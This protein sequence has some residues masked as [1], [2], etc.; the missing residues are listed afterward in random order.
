M[1]K[2]IILGLIIGIMLCLGIVILTGNAD[3]IKNDLTNTIL[4]KN[5]NNVI[6]NISKETENIN[7]TN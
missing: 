1:K 2:G 3:N 4:A 6:N 7:N 5:S